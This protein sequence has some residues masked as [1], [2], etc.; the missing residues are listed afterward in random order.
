MHSFRKK[1][2]ALLSV[3]VLVPLAVIGFLAIVGIRN[4]EQERV[5][6]ISAFL[7][8][9]EHTRLG[10]MAERQALQLNQMLLDNERAVRA[11]CKQYAFNAAAYPKSKPFYEYE[12]YADKDC[13]GLPRYGYCHPEY[14]AFA[15]WD[16]LAGDG[17]SPWIPK[18]VLD[19]VRTD[20]V[21]REQVAVTLDKAASLRNSFTAYQQ[22]HADVIDMVWFVT[23]LRVAYTYPTDYAAKIKANPGMNSVDESQEPYVLNFDPAHNPGR[24][25]GWM[26]IYLDALQK[27]FMTSFV[28]PVYEGDV[29]VGTLGIDV[30][31]PGLA[32]SIAREKV[33][34]KGYAFLLD[35]SGALLAIPEVGIANWVE[36]PESRRAVSQIMSSA[37]S[38]A[39]S[40]ENI[41]CAQRP[42]QELAPVLL[43]PVLA[44]IARETRGSARLQLDNQE[45]FLNFN[46]VPCV[47]WKVIYVQ[48]VAEV[49]VAAS[50]AQEGIEQ[51]AFRSLGGFAFVLAFVFV[52]SVLVAVGAGRHVTRPIS[53]IVEIA[54]RIARDPTHAPRIEVQTRDEFRSLADSLNTMT[55][56]LRRS[57]AKYRELVEN[58]NSIIMRLDIEGRITF[59]NEYAERFFGYNAQEILGK[60]GVGTIVPPVDSTGRD[61]RGMVEEILQNPEKYA[62][63]ENENM[64]KNGERVWVA[65]SN[66]LIALPEENKREILCIGTDMTAHRKMEQQ[67]LQ[68]QRM[69]AIG[70]LAGGVAHDF[71]NLLQAIFGYIELA[72]DN[73]EN[74]EEC[75]SDLHEAYQA[76]ERAAAITRQLL[77]FSRRQVLQL[78]PLDLNQV[79][80]DLTKMIQRL[81]GEHIEL[82]FGPRETPAVILADQGQIEQVLMNLCINARDAMPNGGRLM[83]DIAE[84][85]CEAGAG[86]LRGR[87]APGRYVR[88]IVRDTGC[89]MDPETLKQ[90]FEPFFTTKGP[91]KGTGLG[92]STIY[93]IVR[94]HGG[95]I[96]AE[97]QEGQG[98]EFRVWLPSTASTPEEPG[99]KE[100]PRAAGGP[101]TILLAED[102]EMVRNLSQS[103]L[104]SAGYRVIS[105]PDGDEALARFREHAGEIS[106]LLLD[107][108]MP[109]KSGRAVFEEIR[110]LKPDIKCL[111]ASGYSVSALHADFITENGLDLINKPYRRDELLH[112]VRKVLD[113]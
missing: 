9:T 17:A 23:R 99:R 59:F 5:R 109:C 111:F 91:G 42:L 75:R 85:Q 103:F 77:A 15:D 39:W 93:G 65:W 58:A 29:F 33:G 55:T 100:I 106:L 34:E 69:E 88:L 87:L 66:R 83:I 94:Q 11:L 43:K 105:A 45:V 62:Y 80:A 52:M 1:L 97:S 68:A 92:L 40:P 73:L 25:P 74:P 41:A 90:I 86:M 7:V 72:S 51:E 13:A 57:E 79:T 76:A 10:Q 19:R 107:V 81:I 102:E 8:N 78:R 89:G 27:R 110:A 70:Q 6:E 71:N 98:A 18:P 47:S 44:Q 38:A 61:L 31:L 63:N 26:P 14:G 4:I 53:A 96:D 95:S 30:L 24:N 101:E 37:A 67:L 108:V 36:R 56:A 60:T 48:P 28:A 3:F 104:E 49:M 20:E 84:V 46:T 12:G 54:D 16:R 113:T 32:E 22:T 50:A 64:R 35:A 2:I 82:V 21:F 112:A